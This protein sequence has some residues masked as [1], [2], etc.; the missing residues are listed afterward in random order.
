M[1]EIMERYGPWALVL[2]ATDGTGAAFARQAASEGLNCILVA[3]RLAKLAALESELREAFGVDC[4]TIEADLSLAGAVD[5]IRAGV[6]GRTVGLLVANA[7][8]DP[9]GSH[10]LDA[11]LSD[12]EALVQ[13]NVGT[14]LAC[15]HH[16]GRAMRE[17][18]K[19]GMI[20]VGSGACYGGGPNLA[21]YSGAK[22]F[23]LNFAEGLW[24]EL[25]PHGVDVLTMI[26]GQT[27]TPAFRK[28]LAEK[29]VP[30]P[31]GLARPEDIAAK[32]LASLAD[33][34]LLNW[35][36]GNADAGHLPQSAAQR[37]ARVEMIA[38]AS[39]GIFGSD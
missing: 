23:S 3:R 5:T 20:L 16:F 15:C 38:R 21:V 26:L 31:E 11:P 10:F 27:D 6:A 34:P 14:K 33:G 22:G 13:V 4:V 32:G 18:G 9:N 2:G 19:G 25:R 39:A 8:A 30:V 37:K 28:L 7:G 35:G 24:A 1:S 17:R 36:L 29:G 12:W